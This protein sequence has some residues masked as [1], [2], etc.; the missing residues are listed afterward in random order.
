MGWYLRKS[1]KVGPF[2]VNFSKSGIGYSFGVKGARIGT[3]PHGPYVAGGRGGIYFRQ[4]L[5]T[6]PPLNPTTSNSVPATVPHA[7]CT[8]CGTAIL[9]GNDFCTQCGTA[10]APRGSDHGNPAM[11]ETHD[12]HL[13]WLVLAGAVILFLVLRSLTMMTNTNPE[14]PS[15]ISAAPP[16]TIERPKVPFQVEQQRTPGKPITV[17][18]ASDVN[19]QQLSDVVRYFRA[20]IQSRKFSDLGI[21]AP[22][23]VQKA[24]R[25]T[26]YGAGTVLFYRRTASP[27][28]PAQKK[29]SKVAEYKWGIDGHFQKDSGQV[30][31]E[32]SRATRLF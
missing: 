28:V 29:G 11:E 13:N 8:Q 14:S 16:S 9:P 27:Q 24:P 22:T 23:L 1:V 10:V 7:Y 15:P 21:T 26:S 6:S 2:R 17:W 19:A 5:K 20:E 18:L 25:E 32:A 3:G 30:W 12:H 4:S 31:V